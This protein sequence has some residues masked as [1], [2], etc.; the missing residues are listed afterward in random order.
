MVASGASCDVLTPTHLAQA[1][2][3]RNTVLAEDGWCDVRP[4]PTGHQHVHDKENA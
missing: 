3:F 4:D 1:D 2:G